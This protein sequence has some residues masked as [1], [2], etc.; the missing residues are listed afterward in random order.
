MDTP[1]TATEFFERGVERERTKDYLGAL[2]DFRATLELDPTHAE[3]YF[4]RG[5]LIFCD[6][7]N[8]TIT[9][10]PQLTEAQRTAIIADMEQAIHHATAQQNWEMLAKCANFLGTFR[11]LGV[12]GWAIG[13]YN[14][15]LEHDPQNATYWA[16]RAYC[17]FFEGHDAEALAD[18]AEA[19]RLDP[20][21]LSAYYG[22]GNLY[23]RQRNRAAAAEDYRRVLELNP[24]EF[25]AVYL[26]DYIN[27][28]GK[29]S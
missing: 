8:P 18:Y 28:Y 23:E 15:V 6:V 17:H 4:R 29:K 13:L 2:A 11:G 7:E 22:R 20:N 5:W 21:H 12:S 24:K 1:T 16:G 14:R 3:A 19:I 25:K 27:R 10:I 26:R 9:K